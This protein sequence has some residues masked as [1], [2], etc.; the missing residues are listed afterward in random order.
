MI[1]STS[2]KD[3]AIPSAESQAIFGVRNSR[4]NFSFTT[5]WGDGSHGFSEYPEIDFFRSLGRLPVPDINHFWF[6]SDRGEVSG[7]R[8]EIR[9]NEDAWRSRYWATLANSSSKKTADWAHE[10]EYRI[11]LRSALGSY[12]E[13]KSRILHYRF[14][15]LSGVVFGA[16][17]TEANKVEIVRIIAEK[18]KAENRKEFEFY[19]ARY[20]RRERAFEL[21]R[22]PSLLN[23]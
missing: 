20:A 22:L 23:L 13:R 5:R 21:V 3:G 7:I 12:E 6:L 19:Q 18:C 17:T 8:D 11:E 14:N 2:R 10:D 15:G 9:I 16:N 4:L 1:C